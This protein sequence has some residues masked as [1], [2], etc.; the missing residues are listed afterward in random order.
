[1]KNTLA[2][3]SSNKVRYH[4]HVAGKYRVS[5]H[6]YCNINLKLTKKFQ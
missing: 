3:I 4:D 6:R 2:K 5:A 1:M